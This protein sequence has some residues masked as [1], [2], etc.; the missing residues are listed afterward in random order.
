MS[1]YHP[2]P[3][4]VDRRSSASRYG[5]PPPPP[6]SNSYRPAPPSY[7]A[8][9]PPPSRD[10]DSYAPSRYNDRDRD[11][12]RDRG[13]RDR[14]DRSD[15]YPTSRRSDNHPLPP[16]PNSSSYRDF[17]NSD[18]FRP[19]ESDFTF[20]SDKPS[21][22]G[23]TYNSYR[24]A[25]SDGSRN[26]RRGPARGGY[27][28]PPR[29]GHDNFRGRYGGSGQRRPWKPFKPAERAI[30][31]NTV[32]DKPT[33]DFA[34]SENGVVYRAFDQLSDSDEADM[35]MS[36]S[37]DESAEPTAK[38]ARTTTQADSGDSVPKWS[39]PDPY[40]A[41]PPTEDSDK[42][43]K[44]M[45]Q[46]IRKAR[47]Q[48][49]QGSRTSLPAD[50]EDFIRCDTDSEGDGEN[51]EVFIDPLT[52]QRD[53]DGGQNDS[54]SAQALPPLSQTT[55]AALPSKPEFPQF[56]FTAGTGSQASPHAASSEATSRKRGAD[57]IDLTTSPDLGSRKRTHDDVLKL[58]AH[59][60]LKPAPKQP[61]GG[62]I[63]SEWKAKPNQNSCPWIRPSNS[64]LSMNTR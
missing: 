45:V 21:G 7:A 25:H 36:D 42:K 8:P 29:F 19:P 15:R 61:V 57:V 54:A 14:D 26:A 22:V 46:L 40:T 50:D 2:P 43:K 18:S 9:P 28:R 44:D 52:Y 24:P 63:V 53:K 62:K 47:V 6:G 27:D 23:D 59:A 56:S 17:R 31:Q 13:G 30:L 32:N 55:R 37:E 38:R 48:P 33:E 3:P 1:N 35:D 41:L 39:N 60:K 49:A 64:K 20:R 34:D 5:P 58:P 10:Y 51:D 11:H 12:G 4:G 16:K